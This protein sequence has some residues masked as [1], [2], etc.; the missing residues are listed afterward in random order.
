M[1]NLTLLQRI[2]ALFPQYNPA[3]IAAAIQH[4]VG[5]VRYMDEGTLA[6]E[7]DLAR[8][9]EERQPGYL[10]RMAKKEGM[11]AEFEAWGSVL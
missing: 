8:K 7:G 9:C 2:H 6:V 1:P 5:G 3:G 10:E 11:A 4:L